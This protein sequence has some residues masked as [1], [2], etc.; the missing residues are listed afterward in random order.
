MTTNTNVDVEKMSKVELKAAA[1][2]AGL[3][4]GKMSLLQIRMAL[5]DLDATKCIADLLN[6]GVLKSGPKPAKKAVKVVEKTKQV[7]VKKDGPLISKDGPRS[8][9]KLSQCFDLYKVNQKLARKDIMAL[10]IKEVKI[11]KAC[12]NT[13]VSLCVGMLKKAAKK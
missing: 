6:A 13:Y 10:F 2:K 3:K 5:A 11:S 1:K 7:E 4:V 8:G 9:T 12:A